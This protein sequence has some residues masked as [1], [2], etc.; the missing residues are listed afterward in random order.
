MI[1]DLSRGKLESR[2]RFTVDRDLA[3]QKLRQHLWASPEFYLL[4]LV[5]AAHLAGAGEVSVWA[6]PHEVELSYD[7]ESFGWE[8]AEALEGTALSPADDE[9]YL[10]AVAVQGALGS[11]PS[12]LELECHGFRHQWRPKTGWRSGPI[13]VDGRIVLRLRRPFKERLRG[14]LRQWVDQDLRDWLGGRQGYQPELSLLSE[15]CRFLN[16]CLLLNGRPLRPGFGTRAAEAGPDSLWGRHV[17]ARAREVH[18]PARSARGGLEVLD[19]DALLDKAHRWLGR[20]LDAVLRFHLETGLRTLVAFVRHGVVIDVHTDSLETTGLTAVV[21]TH[22]L[23]TDVTGL[24]V[25]KDETYHRKMRWL[26][27]R[28]RKALSRL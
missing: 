16:R 18:I 28:A 15:R 20:P 24:S 7:S 23:R 14:G 8:E 22:G 9:R 25:V 19:T 13:E 11:R 26:D 27:E 5:Q 6:G 3:L 2:G 12:R 21:P 10:L 17:K 4:K 1:E